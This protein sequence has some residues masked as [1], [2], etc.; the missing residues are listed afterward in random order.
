[1]IAE[2]MSIAPGWIAGPLNIPALGLS[3]LAAS[4]VR[5]QVMSH[6]VCFAARLSLEC[7]EHRHSK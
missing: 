5:S 2:I 4:S 7:N 1:M 6:Q 3:G